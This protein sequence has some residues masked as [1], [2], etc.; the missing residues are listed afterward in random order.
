M[1]SIVP[2]NCFWEIGGEF[3][4]LGGTAFPRAPGYLWIPT[5]IKT[6]K[7]KKKKNQNKQTN[8]QTNQNFEESYKKIKSLPFKTGPK[9]LMA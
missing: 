7:E 5:R 8:K 6:E 1:H 9:Q 4:N 3:G 2:R